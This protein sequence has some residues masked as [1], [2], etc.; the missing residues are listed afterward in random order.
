M[1]CSVSWKRNETKASTQK[2]SP[3][4][5]SYKKLVIYVVFLRSRQS[6]N[7]SIEQQNIH[8]VKEACRKSLKLNVSCRPDFRKSVR[9][10][11]FQTYA[12]KLL[13]CVSFGRKYPITLKTYSIYQ[14][15]DT[16]FNSVWTT[17]I[18]QTSGG[19]EYN[20][21]LER[22]LDGGYGLVQSAKELWNYW[23]SKPWCWNQFIRKK[24][25]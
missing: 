5:A 21:P 25:N 14:Q 22:S 3:R 8:N 2:W 1:L 11:K 7:F 6:S 12:L 4:A 16:L 10:L 19:L 23:S 20:Y 24:W 17:I 15:Q 13:V 18:L 9:A